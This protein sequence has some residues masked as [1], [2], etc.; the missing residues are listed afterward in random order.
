MLR[1]EIDGNWEP[2]DFIEV[3]Q[4]IESLYYKASISGTYYYPGLH[5]WRSP[6]RSTDFNQFLEQVN[7]W[8]LA[9]ARLFATPSSRL[10]VHRIEYG[11][12]GSLDFLGA[13]RIVEVL[14]DAVFRG[15]EFYADRHIKVERRD[16]ATLETETARENLRTLELENARRIIELREDFPDA[17]KHEFA[18]LAVKDQDQIFARIAEGKIVG[19]SSE[20]NER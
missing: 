13:A 15:I 8:L 11:S 10:R 17:W 5:F 3:L 2:E 6:E 20:D 14:V 19:V 12:P 4:S 1:I 18:A 9:E 16:Q 7:V